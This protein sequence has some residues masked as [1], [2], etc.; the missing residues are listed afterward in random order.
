MTKAAARACHAA[1][2]ARAGKRARC[3]ALRQAVGPRTWPQCSVTA[4]MAGTSAKDMQFSP[5]LEQALPRRWQDDGAAGALKVRAP[6]CAAFTAKQQWNFAVAVFAAYRRTCIAGR[7][8]INI[9][10]SFTRACIFTFKKSAL[11]YASQFPPECAW[12]RRR[13]LTVRPVRIRNI[14]GSII[15][16]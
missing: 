14:D 15:T 9:R 1:A 10:Y 16:T 8:A 13:E 3:Q 6:A 4:K 12:E 5:L 2:E 11:P 7:Y